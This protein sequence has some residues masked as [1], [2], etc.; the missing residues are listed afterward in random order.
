MNH[1]KLKKENIN[2]PEKEIE[3]ED[4]QINEDED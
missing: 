2:T 1:L 4:E 3:K